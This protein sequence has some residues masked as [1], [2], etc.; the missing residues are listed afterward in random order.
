[1]C[2]CPER[3]LSASMT[4]ALRLPVA[5]F[6]LMERPPPGQAPK[7]AILFLV[8]GEN[9]PLVKTAASDGFPSAVYPRVYF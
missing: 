7:N 5:V 2:P 9:R 6:K 4:G 8:D 3:Y 1:M